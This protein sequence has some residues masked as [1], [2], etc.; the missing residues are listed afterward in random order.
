M[1]TLSRVGRRI[2][3]A[4]RIRIFHAYALSAAL[5]RLTP[6]SRRRSKWLIGWAAVEAMIRLKRGLDITYLPF[7]G[8]GLPLVLSARWVAEK[9]TLTI[10]VDLRPRGAPAMTVVGAMP[11]PRARKRA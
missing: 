11:P 6:R 2:P 4:A 9:A 7:A 3:R 5:Q 1:K 10:E 8:A